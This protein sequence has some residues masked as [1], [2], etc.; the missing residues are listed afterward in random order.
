MRVPTRLA[1]L[2]QEGIELVVVDECHHSMAKSYL[3][4]LSVL[5][6]KLLGFT[7][8]VERLDGKDITEL[9]GEPVYEKSILYMILN[10]Y[11][12]D[13]RSY[14]VR[15][16]STS[17][18]GVS[19]T[20]G[21][22]QSARLTSAI[23]RPDRNEVIVDAYKEHANG[24]STIAFAVTVEHAEHL[25][26]SFR[27]A[28]ISA[29]ALSGETPDRQREELLSKYQSGEIKV[30]VNVM[31]FVEGFD[32]PLT[33]CIIMARPTKSLS[34][35]K[36][37]LGRGLRLYTDP[38][39][40]KEKKECIFIDITDNCTN[41]QLEPQGVNDALDGIPLREG[42]TIAE[43]QVAIAEERRKKEEAKRQAEEEESDSKS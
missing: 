12:A 31:L 25:A 3:S 17:L 22:Y 21:D 36:Q 34:L 13:I 35:F 16:K 20:G 18:D 23:D 41:H 11:L 37:C 29:A 42:L 9:F 32:A 24:L 33:S 8:T 2:E 1:Q 15:S 39:T 27:E 4:I 7:A 26:E 10:K 40:G 28:G 19:T 14:A 30:L 38:I 5:E 6:A 43:L